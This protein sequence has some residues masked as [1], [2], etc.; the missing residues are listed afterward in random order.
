M[1]VSI[2][3]FYTGLIIGCLIT[4]ICFVVFLIVKSAKDKQQ[5][6]EIKRNETEM[7]ETK[8]M[9]E[10]LDKLRTDFFVNITHEFRTPL[11]I[12]RGYTLLAADDIEEGKADK[13][14]CDNLRHAA[15]EANRLSGL[16]TELLHSTIR[17]ENT[18]KTGKLD[19]ITIFEPTIATC[20]LITTKNNNSL[21]VY[22]QDGLPSV[23][24]NR[25][26]ILQV[27]INLIAN[28]NRH[29]RDGIIK[30][31]A[32]SRNYRTNQEENIDLKFVTVAV[33]DT[34]TGIFMDI[35]PYV[36]ERRVS[37]T[38]V[39]GQPGTG[40]GLSICKEIVESH[41]G[42]IGISEGIDGI[43]TKIWFT[44]PACDADE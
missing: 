44:L 13:D 37:G 15:Q 34:G 16:A 36:F 27:L 32:E 29:T 19:I 40:L 21:E 43:G 1:D 5:A 17:S 26:M 39:D 9:M 20:R 38:P 3:T 2:V 10:Q 7:R 28:A 12:I 25:D 4:T 18:P 41:G 24:A 30:L 22:I 23:K 31:I 42:E 35:L 11:T 33:S 8:R 6:N 14:T